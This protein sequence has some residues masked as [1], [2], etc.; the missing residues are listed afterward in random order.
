MAGLGSML[1]PYGAQVEESASVEKVVRREI[2]RDRRR[3]DRDDSSAKQ[4]QVFSNLNTMNVISQAQQSLITHLSS[5]PIDPATMQPVVTLSTPANYGE[6]EKSVLKWAANGVLLLL[7]NQYNVIS[8]LRAESLMGFMANGLSTNHESGNSLFGGG[9]SGL[10][11]LSS[12]AGGGFG[13]QSLFGGGSA[14][15][16]AGVTGRWIV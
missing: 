9:L 3:R 7:Q 8:A 2:R 15:V 14:G 4:L 10:L 13:L 16:L 6:R 1:V 11:I 12:V 5:P